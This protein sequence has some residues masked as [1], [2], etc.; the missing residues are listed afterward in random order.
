MEKLLEVLAV[1]SSSY[2]QFR[3]FSYIIRHIQDIPNTTYYVVDGNIYIQRGI[4]EKYPCMVAHMDTVHDIV[5]DLYPMYID[6]NIT[7]FNRVTM[8][9]TGIGG[10]DKVGI[11]IA[12]QC[13]REFDNIKVAFF[14][15]EEVGCQGSYLAD[16]GFFKD[17][18]FVLQCD[19][20]G[21]SDFVTSASGVELS[22]KSFQDDVLP[23]ITGFGYKFASGM[24]TDVMALKENGVRC[25][26]AN[27]SCG[28]YNPHH[29]TE[30]VNVY[31]VENCLEMCKTIIRYCVGE[32]K[33]K[34]KTKYTV[35]SK[36]KTKGYEK[37]VTHWDWAEPKKSNTIQWKDETEWDGKAHGK[38]FGYEEDYC[39]DCWADVP[40][41]DGLCK[42]CHSWYAGEYGGLTF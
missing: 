23:I 17:C 5:E 40:Y 31:D 16:M 32:Y 10:D 42:M 27:M 22:G 34:Y 12:L 18:R 11:Y 28:Y 6:G 30:Y 20:K 13:L 35:Y 9:Q 15:D 36:P 25:A 8:E 39:R 2:E 1:Q 37:P 7:G 41:Q 33:H 24:M 19:R 3:M 4:A 38:P 21:C 29:H 14:R 26:V